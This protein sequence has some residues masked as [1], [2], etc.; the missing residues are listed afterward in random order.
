MAWGH[1][2]DNNVGPWHE[3]IGNIIGT[4]W[5]VL[6]VESL[7]CRLCK[8]QAITVLSYLPNYVTLYYPVVLCGLFH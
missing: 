2:E 3:V 5:S 6:Y 7:V 1:K 4:I 8:G